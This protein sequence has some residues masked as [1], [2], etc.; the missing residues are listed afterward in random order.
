MQPSGPPAS[1][2]D[3]FPQS[4]GYDAPI[5][6]CAVRCA[7]LRPGECRPSISPTVRKRGERPPRSVEAQYVLL[8]YEDEDFRPAHD[9][10][11][12][13]AEYGQ[14]AGALAREGS[15][16]AGEK[17]DETGMLLEIPGGAGTMLPGG[18][19]GSPL[20][21]LGGYFVISAG[22]RAEA[23]AIAGT[24]PH[25]RHGGRIVVR[26]IVPT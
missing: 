5:A 6:R 18:D 1:P 21:R 8:L 2:T 4:G 26:P 14:W 20:G 24:N 7:R 10:D 17:L 11:A 12:L 15:L 13:V 16:V 25:L 23:L 3:R 19:D 9:E 22:D